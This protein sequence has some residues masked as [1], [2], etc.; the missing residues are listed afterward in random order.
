M[1]KNILVLALLMCSL[2][3]SLCFGQDTPSSPAYGG[4]LVLSTTSDP[5]SFNDIM[6]KETS[7]STVTQYIFEGLTTSNPYNLK[8]EPNLAR[9]WD[10]SADGKVW[11]FYLREDVM[12][13][14]GEP[15]TADD[16][17]F[18]FNRLI[19]NPD[20]PSSAKDAFTVQGE[21]FQV[22]KLDDFAVQFTLPVKFAPFLRSMGQ[23]ILPQHK[24]E[25]SVDKGEFNFTWGIDT[26]PKEIVGTGPFKLSE[27]RPGER[28]VFTPNPFYWKKSE[29]GD[30]L[31]YLNKIIYL[32]VQNADTS[33]LKFMDG[34]LDYYGVRGSDFP[35]VKPL[36]EEKNFTVYD[37]GP[38]FG[39]NFIFFNQ[40]N[41]LNPETNQPYVDPAKLT[42]FT[43][44]SFRRAVAHVI[45]KER[46]IEIVM[47]G[48]GYP[49]HAAMSPSAGFFHN[50]DVM[51]YAYDPNK[52]QEILRAAGFKD[53]D[54]DGLIEDQQ[55]NV[56]Q[57]NL[58]TNSGAVE[59]I[60]IAGIIRH[61]LERLGMKI[62]FQ[63][64]EFN[65]LVS[66]LTSNF[67]F[68][69]IILGLTGGIEPHFGKNVWMSNG[70]L[71][72]W[73]PG[74]KTPQTAWEER[75]DEIFTRAVQ[76]LD[77]DKRKALYDEFQM[78]VSEQLPLIYTALSSNL[79]AVRD[80]FGNLDPTS[81]GG[82][83]HNIEEIYVLQQGVP[84]GS[85]KVAPGK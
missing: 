63:A 13:N 55:G 80:K 4:K 65:T 23:A 34:E 21:I 70:Q 19:Y 61:D 24:L 72:M 46:I 14:D 56:V 8:V 36:E 83:F 43:D 16:V 10:V 22:E 57:F 66:K 67:Q 42:W 27:Y 7:T 39:T 32:I 69:A 45:D 1:K 37:G 9:S 71:H 78:I 12:W 58:Y 2:P 77:P 53:R 18:T 15:F 26:D 31:P 52:A 30:R 81:Y 47:N 48:L 84:T 51:K 41:R 50:P 73:N 29:D 79:Y 3:A 44:L 60:Q 40:N 68:D 49:Q 76:E 82:A 35:L 33:L 75:I 11:T 54:G 64:L 62:N 38:A 74:Q 25:K 28:L 5:R 85:R 6:A 59:R 20:I 17:V